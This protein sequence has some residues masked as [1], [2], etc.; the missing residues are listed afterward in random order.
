MADPTKDMEFILRT[1]AEGD[2]AEKTIEGLDKVADKAKEAA[3]AFDFSGL[4]T[5]NKATDTGTL[6]ERIQL[7]KDYVQQSGTAKG[8]AEELA[9]AEEELAR[10]VAE[11]ADALAKATEETEKSDEARQKSAEEAERLAAQEKQRHDDVREARVRLNDRE[12]TAAQEADKAAMASLALRGASILAVT[13]LASE[14]ARQVQEVSKE[15]EKLGVTLPDSV[16]ATGMAIEA[17]TNPTKFLF[18]MLSQGARKTLEDLEKTQKWVKETKDFL[19]QLQDEKRRS[20]SAFA[21]G[22][23]AESF[24]REMRA[25][26]SLNDER[27]RQQRIAGNRQD[28]ARGREDVAT[29]QKIEQTQRTKDGAAETFGLAQIEGDVAKRELE[30]QQA[31]Q[32]KQIEDA[33][34]KAAEFGRQLDAAVQSTLAFKNQLDTATE[35]ERKAFENRMANPDAYADAK[36]TRSEK[37]SAFKGAQSRE[38]QL[39]DQLEEAKGA[40][41]E[42]EAMSKDN[43]VQI[44][45]EF[46]DAMGNVNQSM[47]D[48]L[49]QAA[50]QSVAAAEKAKQEIESKGGS[51]PAAID[52]LVATISGL[53]SD[54]KPDSGQVAPILNALLQLRSSTLAKDNEFIKVVNES[55]AI[56][57]QSHAGLEQVK[58]QLNQLR[59]EIDRINRSR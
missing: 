36:A 51:V 9:A 59:A 42:L 4:A 8:Y 32:A 16:K 2:G 24:E 41:R 5:G 20:D 52:S 33:K 18:D 13:K 46:G 22:A 38:Q 40:I 26:K 35:A 17:I 7:I 54:E 30:R 43:L 39:A 44:K 29:R 12:R 25:L 37:E 23:I 14:A 3:K 47:A 28:I 55:I 48:A 53:I 21:T 6:R 58:V 11:T 34:T 19:K 10:R 50:Q 57:Q 31:D 49:T 15:A 1:K 27:E 56:T 45:Q